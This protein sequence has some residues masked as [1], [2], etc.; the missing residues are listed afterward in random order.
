MPANLGLDPSTVLGAVFW[1]V[2]AGILTSALLL[3]LGVLITNVLIPW[4]QALVYQGADLSGVWTSRQDLGGI[5][6][7]YTMTLKQSAHGLTGAMT[8][9]KSGAPPGPQG[10]Y[11]Q[12][13]DIT[14]STWEG[15]VTLNMRST[16]RRSLSFATSLLQI[17]DRGRSLVGQLVYRSSQVDQVAA[18][19][20][21]WTRV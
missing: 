8:I 12:G 9:T 7:S 3:L 11:V 20:V 19:P 18:E 21:H 4:Y 17:A 6:Y 5:Q 16:D 2:V 15:F 1:G 14:G 10:D 13:F